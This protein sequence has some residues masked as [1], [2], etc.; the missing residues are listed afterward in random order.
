M[1]KAKARVFV[2]LTKVDE[3]NRLVYGTITQEILDKSGEVMD[4]ESSKPHFEKWSTDIHTASGG[5]SKG[6]LRVMHSLNVAGKVTEM[7]F[8]DDEKSI[9]VCAKVVD[10]SQWN[11]CLEGCYTGF[12]VG[13]NY[14]KR[15]TDTIDGEK[16]KKFTA[17][18]NEVSLVDNPCVPSATFAL[19]KAD[20]SEVEV[21]FKVENDDD[22]WPAFSKAEADAAET[23]QQA[24]APIDAAKIDEAKPDEEKL[25]T[26]PKPEDK[27]AEP[28]GN[29]GGD[30]KPA[31]VEK[32]AQ[33]S[34]KDIAAKAEELCKAAGDASKDWMDFIPAATEALKKGI[35]ATSAA[36]KDAPVDPKMPKPKP[37]E[38]LD[39]DRPK[40]EGEA[41]PVDEDADKA[42]SETAEK[43][44]PQ[45]V[46]QKWCTSD[47]QS[48]L[49][50]A[51][52]DKHQEKLNKAAA[53][54]EPKTDAE[55][56]AARLAKAIDGGAEDLP[57]IMDDLP[58]LAKA[59]EAIEAGINAEGKPAMQKGMY[60]VS[61]FARMIA[62]MAGLTTQVKSDAG[63]DQSDAMK[64]SLNAWAESFKTYADSE[65]TKILSGID[66]DTIVE[67]YDYYY[68][69]A[70]ADGGDQDAQ[71][72]VDLIDAH[73]ADADEVKEGLA[74]AWGGDVEVVSPTL[75]KRFTDL[76]AENT[77]L[78]KVAE[79]AV[80]A[81]ETLT[82]RV[83]TIENK[84]MPRAPRTSPV[85]KTGDGTFLGKAATSEEDKMAV[86]QD[87][88]KTHGPDKM[89][90]MMIKASHNTGGVKMGA[91]K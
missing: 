73:K 59:V 78:K 42:A 45:G 62:D 70:K 83:E 57:D 52:A 23:E 68:A 90:E 35:T 56:L 63:T 40:E 8:N 71:D 18:P 82:K 15:W 53:E 39:G 75:E 86:L 22:K 88:L 6:N 25:D 66:D 16:V 69:C 9:E 30:P 34:N 79:T 11:M 2:P 84:P 29:G 64:E 74:K 67:C 72:I 65:I 24:N 55:K 32:T 48:F 12:S 13:G 76:Q 51:S 49:K 1:S 4:Y 19:A 20:G 38:T 33:P 58:R 61:R 27:P 47:G 89:A 31:A 14:E 17:K 5:L 80:A 37:L 50:K 7:E 3:E 21:E 10:D 44:T 60:T 43:V 85:D 91:I 81:V 54:V 77:E 46:L 36:M 41:A 87:M 28:V 26:D